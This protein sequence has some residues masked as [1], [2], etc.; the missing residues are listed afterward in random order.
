[1]LLLDES[2]YPRTELRVTCTSDDVLGPISNV[3]P[4]AGPRY[5]VRYEALKPGACTVTDRAF[6]VT[7]EII[8]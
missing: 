8:S 3:P 4:E 5:A 7:V 1:M 2:R 6:V